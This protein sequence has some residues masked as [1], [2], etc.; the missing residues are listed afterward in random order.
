VY[1]GYHP[2][3]SRTTHSRHALALALGCVLPACASKIPSPEPLCGTW[4]DSDGRTERWWI[5][6]GDLRGEAK[7]PDGTETLAL[8]AGRRGHVYVAKPDDAEPTE[9]API[10]PA[11]ARLP[12]GAATAARH[13]L[14]PPIARWVWV[15]YDHD[16]PQEIQYELSDYSHLSVVIANPSDAPG[17]H[18]WK[19][20][21]LIRRG[22]CGEEPPHEPRLDPRRVPQLLVPTEEMP[23]VVGLRWVG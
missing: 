8:I 16:F 4:S 5:D 2:G 23:P 20:W 15:N 9:F 22:A 11:R 13:G 21:V 10:D 1:L 7:T 17:K 18:S 3:M 19:L 14:P 12:W 6:G